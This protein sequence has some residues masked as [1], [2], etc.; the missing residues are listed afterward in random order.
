[1]LVKWYNSEPVSGA[2][3]LASKLS[4][5]DGLVVG[6]VPK[7]QV[8]DH[9]LGGNIVVVNTVVVRLNG[10]FSLEAKNNNTK[11]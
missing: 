10:N 8:V 6:V 2:A 1:M 5:H 4:S 3:Y 7:V 9:S 11:D